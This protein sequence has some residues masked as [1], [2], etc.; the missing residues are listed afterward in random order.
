MGKNHTE[1]KMSYANDAVVALGQVELS[2]PTPILRNGLPNS[3]AKFLREKSGRV[4]FLGGSITQMN[5]WSKLI[6]EDLRSRFPETQFQFNNA[7]IGGTNSTFGVFRFD[8]DVL[9]KG[10]VDLLFIEFAVNDASDYGLANQ[11]MQAMEGIIRKARQA[12]PATDILV[13]Y[14]ADEGKVQAYRESKEP[15]VITHHERIMAHY[16]IPVINLALEMTRRLDAGHFVWSDFS[17][18]SCHPLP[19][20]DAQYAGFIKEFLDA[21]WRACTALASTKPHPLPAPLFEDHLSGARLI[22]TK[23][24]QGWT[25]VHG[26][27]AE[28]VCNYSGPVD[29]LIATMPGETLTLSF[30]GTMLAMNGIAGM[31]AGVLEISIDG[32]AFTEMDLFDNYCHRFHRPVFHMLAHGLANGPHTARLRVADRQTPLSTGHAVRVLQFGASSHQA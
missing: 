24:A 4:A 28:L 11:R 5:G 3:S 19:L 2:A 27:L 8:D 7:G 23:D 31:D 15:L 29:V 30:V 26:W 13:L 10:P 22:G 16:D 18:D 9:A 6:E 21:A 17:R 12:N 1:D 32:G 20:G 14:L 25:M